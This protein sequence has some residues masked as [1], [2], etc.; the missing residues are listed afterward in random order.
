MRT[1]D[2]IYSQGTGH[3]VMR[4]GAVHRIH[5]HLWSSQVGDL[6]DRQVLNLAHA[7]RLIPNFQLAAVSPGPG[8]FRH[9]PHISV[10]TT[11]A[12]TNQLGS[13]ILGI[14]ARP[15]KP[16]PRSNK[17]RPC[18]P[19]GLWLTH[20]QYKRPPVG[21]HS[22]ELRRTCQTSGCPEHCRTRGII[23][24]LGGGGR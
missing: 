12:V 6:E 2:G 16:R 10:F 11:E 1:L 24:G 21:T 5:C 17:K 8:M 3:P 19:C 23:S 13:H 20:I 15:R 18:R 22:E 14:S 4:Q 9:L 7:V